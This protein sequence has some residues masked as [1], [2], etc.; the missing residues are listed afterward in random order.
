MHFSFSMVFSFSRRIR[1]PTLCVSHFLCFKVFLPCSRSYSVHFSLLIIFRV[2]CHYP[3]PTMRVS[4]FLGFSKHHIPGA[5]VC[6]SHFPHFSV[7]SPYSRS[8][9]VYFSFFKFFVFITIFL[10]LKYE[11][12]IFL[13]SQI[14]RHIPG[15]TVCI[16]HFSCF[17]VF[18]PIIQV[19]PCVC[20]TLYIF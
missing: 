5:T 3:G 18:L 7:F 13:V 2:S 20:L 8:Y 4:H 10:I 14:S 12:L 19:I 9:S 11:F 16:S 15:P 1:F 6:V 17:S